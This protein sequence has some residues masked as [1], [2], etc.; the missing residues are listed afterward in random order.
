[1]DEVFMRKAR[2]K[3]NDSKRE[4]ITGRGKREGN[5]KERK[6]ERNERTNTRM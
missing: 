1:M 4:I 2:E 6:R 5:I 3:L